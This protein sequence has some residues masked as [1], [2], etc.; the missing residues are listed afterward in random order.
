MFDGAKR[1]VV[2]RFKDAMTALASRGVDST[3][4]TPAAPDASQVI[5]G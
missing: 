4:A 1:A 2:V 5:S 3:S